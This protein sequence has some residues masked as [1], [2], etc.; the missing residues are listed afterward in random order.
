[1]KYIKIFEHWDREAHNRLAK[2]GLVKSI[3]EY[4]EEL[5]NNSDTDIPPEILAELAKVDDPYIKRAVAKNLNTPVETLDMLAND[6]Y[7]GV[8]SNVAWNPNTST[9]VL[10]RLTNDEETI[11]SMPAIDNLNLRNK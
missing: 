7:W 9:R 8:R 1:M 5:R 4:E 2:M 10:I 11:V 6:D 3:E